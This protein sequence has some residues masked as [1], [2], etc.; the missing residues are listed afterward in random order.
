MPPSCPILRASVPWEEIQGFKNLSVFTR[1]SMGLLERPLSGLLV[2]WDSRG[3]DG[4]VRSPDCWAGVLC[5]PL[6]AAAPKVPAPSRPLV[7]A[8]L[9]Q[10]QCLRVT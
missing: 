4:G 9:V 3:W 7:P 5:S 1:I 10:A 6:Y 2:P 8:P